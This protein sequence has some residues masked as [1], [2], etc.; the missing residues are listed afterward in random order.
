MFIFTKNRAYIKKAMIQGLLAVW[1]ICLGYIP[2]GLAFGVLAQK[3]GLHPYE[4]GLMSL[5]VFA[6][7]S[8][9]IAVSMLS[10]GATAASI[11][12]TTFAV[13]LRHLLMSSSLAVFMG[14]ATMKKL[15]LFAYGVT[16]E[17][18]A[19]NHTNFSKKIWG[20]NQALVVNHA[21]NITWITSTVV[22]GYSGQFIPA[23]AFGIDYALSAMFICLLIFQLKGRK[24]VITA[25]LAGITAVILSLVIPGH[26]YVILASVLA[27]TLGVVFNS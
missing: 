18:F 17:S 2:I 5:L 25:I 26:S 7:S 24:Y 14:K 15:A 20:L 1:P 21:A 22:G 4:I 3:A 9:F 23:G 11:I 12:I 19:V 10:A 16:D 13:N 6:G 27:A 8:Q